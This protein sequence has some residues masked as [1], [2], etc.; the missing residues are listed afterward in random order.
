[1]FSS[2]LWMYDVAVLLSERLVMVLSRVLI[3][4]VRLSL[5]GV[6]SPS[7]FNTVPKCFVY[8]GVFSSRCESVVSRVCVAIVAS[9]G[10][11]LSKFHAKLV[12]GGRGVAD[13]AL[14]MLTWHLLLFLP[15]LT[16]S[17]RSPARSL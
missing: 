2:V 5:V 16:T 12:N 7:M 4:A 14:C 11:C 6:V 3:L 15:S 8:V 17:D 13:G 1:M 9:T 10:H